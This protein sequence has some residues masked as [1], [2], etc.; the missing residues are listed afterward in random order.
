[1]LG[2]KVDVVGD[3]HEVAN[4]EVGIHAARCIAHKEVLNAQFVH[5]ANRKGYLLHVVTFVIVETT[6]QGHD[7]L[8]A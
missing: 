4:F 7:V 1:M 6:L 8:T 5:H 2:H 3:E